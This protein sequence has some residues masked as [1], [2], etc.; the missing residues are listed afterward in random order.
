M[1]APIVS[2][3][4]GVGLADGVDG[5]AVGGG[6]GQGPQDKSSGQYGFVVNDLWLL[7]VGYCG[8]YPGSILLVVSVQDTTTTCP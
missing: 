3:D 6:V 8:S 2:W 5:G 1:I 4:G 7:D